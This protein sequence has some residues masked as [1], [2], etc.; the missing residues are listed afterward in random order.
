MR[1]LFVGV[2]VPV[3]WLVGAQVAAAQLTPGF[4]EV[5]GSPFATGSRPQSV[6][7]SPSGAFVA[8]ANLGANDVSVFSVSSSGSLTPVSGSP[9]AAGAGPDSVAFNPSGAL[10]AVA[11][12]RANTVSV[13]SVSSSGSLTPLPPE[14]GTSGSPFATGADP[15]SVAFSQFSYEGKGSAGPTLAVANGA[16]NSVSMFDVYGLNGSGGP[17]LTPVQGSPFPAGM[18]PASVT[19]SR[20]LYVVAVANRG[21]NTVSMS[22]FQGSEEKTCCWPLAGSPVRGS[23]ASGP[24][25]V[26]FSPDGGLLATANAGTNNVSVFSV[27]DCTTQY[28]QGF[29]SG[30]NAGYLA[31]FN[32]GWNGEYR[33]NGAWQAGYKNGMRAARERSRTLHALRDS[34]R[35]AAQ[36]ALAYRQRDAAA[37]ATGCDEVFNSAFNQALGQIFPMPP[38]QLTPGNLGYNYNNGFNSGWNSAYKPAFNQGFRAGFAKLATQLNGAGTGVVTVDTTTNPSPETSTFSGHL[39][40]VGAFTLTGVLS[41]TAL[42]PPPSIPFTVTGTETL[43]AANGD[44]IFGAVSGTGTATPGHSHGTSLVTITGGTGRFSDARGFYT[45]TPSLV[46]T[47]NGP[48]ATGKGTLT[49]QG[50][51]SY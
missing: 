44:E 36:A 47:F 31:G 1:K 41:F 5:S 42:G 23:A 19:F 21:D 17:F 51:I 15:D 40:H 49:I 13:F 8:T 7:F 22:S 33:P 10:V 26:A 27:V 11:D 24:V 38:S 30:I 9:F 16:D 18:A 50:H 39:S 34:P 25:S 45:E 4:V 2:F 12:G 48:I 6:V 14:I 35:I 20:A 29:N 46:V 28:N 32:A 37:T 3:V 43:V